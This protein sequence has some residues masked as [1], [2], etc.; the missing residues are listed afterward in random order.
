VG[1]KRNARF[2]T[3]RSLSMSEQE[4]NTAT[5]ERAIEAPNRRDFG[6]IGELMQPDLG[7]HDLYGGP[8]GGL[9]DLAGPSGDVD[10][11][12]LLLQA[13]PDVHVE[14]K[15]MFA[16]GNQVAAHLVMTGTHQGELYGTP[17]TGKRVELDDMHIYRLVDGRIAE[18][19]QVDDVWGWLRQI[20]AVE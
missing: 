2:F 8:H 16:S 6:S 3:A 17:G 20:G 13:M 7:R 12:Q 19:W 1:P 15:Q 18:T 10:G 14:I 9:G 11:T 4:T 5:I